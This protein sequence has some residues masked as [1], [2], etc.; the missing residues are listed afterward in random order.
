MSNRL[1]RIIA[2]RVGQQPKDEN[3][4]SGLKAWQKFVGGL[5]TVVGVDRQHRNVSLV[6]NDEGILLRLPLNQAVGGH[7]IHGDFFI[8][9][10]DADGEAID[11]TDDDIARWLPLLTFNAGPSKGDA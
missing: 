1:V 4:D 9:R 3:I 11:L 5:I 7:Y 8:F 6:C 10:S 2:C